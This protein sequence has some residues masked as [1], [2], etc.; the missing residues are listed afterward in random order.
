MSVFPK[1]ARKSSMLM[2]DEGWAAMEGRAVA[3][4]CMEREGRGCAGCVGCVGCVGGG[5]GDGLY[6]A[7]I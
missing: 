7:A 2:S 5:C 4:P 6:G 1:D 3:C